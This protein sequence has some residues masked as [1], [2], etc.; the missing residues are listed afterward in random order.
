MVSTHL[1]KISQI[2]SS[3]QVRVK[4]INIWNHHLVNDHALKWWPR[5]PWTNWFLNNRFFH[6]CKGFQIMTFLLGCLAGSCKLVSKL[7]YFTS[8]PDEINL[9]KKGVAGYFS[10]IYY[11]FFDFVSSHILVKKTFESSLAKK[12]GCQQPT[13][14][15]SAAEPAAVGLVFR[16]LVVVPIAM[17]SI[18]VRSRSGSDW[19]SQR[20]FAKK[21]RL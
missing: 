12:W 2:G 14:C 16:H 13:A 7:V 1:K 20:S 10:S 5:L 19:P 17:E 18:V 6:P 4:I 11:C 3:P 8:L 9:L 21:R 15:Q